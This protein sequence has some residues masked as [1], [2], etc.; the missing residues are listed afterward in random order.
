M[1][2]VPSSRGGGKLDPELKIVGN[3]MLLSYQCNNFALLAVGI[4]QKVAM[5]V[6]TTLKI[7]VWLWHSVAF[8]LW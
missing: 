7:L 3:T 1:C 4:T 5:C 8:G 6:A 2:N